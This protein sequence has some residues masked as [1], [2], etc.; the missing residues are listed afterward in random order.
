MNGPTDNEKALE[1]YVS[2]LDRFSGNPIVAADLIKVQRNLLF[3]SRA[4]SNDDITR[5]LDRVRRMAMPHGEDT[6]ELQLNARESVLIALQATAPE[7]RVAAVEH[8]RELRAMIGDG[9]SADPSAEKH[10]IGAFWTLAVTYE[11]KYPATLFSV[12]SDLVAV[13]P[14]P[15]SGAEQLALLACTQIIPQLAKADPL[16]AFVTW[17]Q[18]AQW[19]RAVGDGS[20]MA[21]ILIAAANSILMPDP[22]QPREI[23][24]VLW[25]FVKTADSGRG[26]GDDGVNGRIM[27]VIAAAN[28]AVY[29]SVTRREATQALLERLRQGGAITSESHEGIYISREAISKDPELTAAV[30]VYDQP[31]AE[32]LAYAERW[33]HPDLVMHPDWLGFVKHL[34]Q[35]NSGLIG[36]GPSLGKFENLALQLDAETRHQHA[37]AAEGRLIL[38]TADSP[39]WIDRPLVPLEWSDVEDEAQIRKLVSP[40]AIPDRPFHAN[41]YAIERLRMVKPSFY[42]KG[43]LVEAQVENEDKVKGIVFYLLLPGEQVVVFDG[44][45]NHVHDVNMAKFLKNM[46]QPASVFDY[47]LFFTHTIWGEMGPFRIVRRLDEIPFRRAPSEEAANGVRRSL[48]ENPEVVKDLNDDW[49]VETSVQYADALFRTTFEIDRGG[50]IEMLTDEPV[51]TDLPVHLLRMAGPM[52]VFR[53]E[54]TVS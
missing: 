12:W 48:V 37:T 16:A 38:V 23:N 43:T 28:M 47:L 18:V 7:R 40:L 34:Q 45:S 33:L 41:R 11:A 52:R 44:K 10:L 53:E 26:S 22:E 24:E 39:A 2:E 35:L 54:K 31:V 20:K 42:P 15:P 1:K 13:L 8:Y 36:L 51:V 50:M 29:I 21:A 6:P 27:S 5:L 30:E 14:Q 17:A 49:R 4:F 3:R 25:E 46:D 9:D 19:S 32:T